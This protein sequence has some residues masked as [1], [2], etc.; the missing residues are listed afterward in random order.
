MSKKKKIIIIT[1]I[2]LLVVIF[3]TVALVLFIPYETLEFCDHCPLSMGKVECDV[4]YY[5]GLLSGETIYDHDCGLCE[6]GYRECR[7][8]SG[9]GRYYETKSNFERWF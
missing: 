3:T 4:I 5:V 1:I 9:I 2:S 7:W 6:N 8:C